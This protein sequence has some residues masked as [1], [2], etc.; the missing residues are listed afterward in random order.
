M[1][2][3][4]YVIDRPD[5]DM[6]LACYVIDRPDCEPRVHGPWQAELRAEVE[7]VRADG[8]TRL[9]SAEALSVE[10]EGRSSEAYEARLSASNAEKEEMRESHRGA[11]QAMRD[12]EETRWASHEAKLS[13]QRD[14]YATLE[15]S[16][17][18]QRA[19]AEGHAREVRP[20][21]RPRMC[22]GRM[23]VPHARAACAC[24][25]RVPRA[26]AAGA[27][28]GRVPRAAQSG[29]TQLAPLR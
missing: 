11:L 9:R 20:R 29:R 6:R 21:T 12:S 18:E 7:R 24:R 2:L 1:R 17:H 27:Y 8:E 19:T 3:A 25:G 5:C 22:H 10:R 15:R 14:A 28:R 4:C 13:A 23:R 16:L 26:H